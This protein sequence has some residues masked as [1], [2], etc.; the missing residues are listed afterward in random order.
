MDR[1]I[2]LRQIHIISGCLLLLIVSAC[3]SGTQISK[4]IVPTDSLKATQAP[5]PKKPTDIKY[6]FHYK[7]INSQSSPNDDMFIDSTGQMTF[8]T[9]QQLKSG[10]LKN[11]T[12]FAYLEPSDDD[13]LYYFVRQNSLIDIE[14]SDVKPQCPTGDILVITLYRCDIKKWLKLETSTCAV[15]FNL[16]SSGQ[17]KL[18]QQFIPFVRR[19]ASRY[20]PGFLEN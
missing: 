18:F 10:K 2:S 16:L 6:V 20:R 12:G 8:S 14:P 15:D 13:T 5:P 7:V 11:P 19:L 3:H 1:G 9:N 4:D 17:R